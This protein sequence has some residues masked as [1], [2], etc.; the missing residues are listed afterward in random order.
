MVVK[1]G[2]RTKRPPPERRAASDRPALHDDEPS[3]FQRLHE[4]LGD[5][6]SHHLASVVHPLAPAV[7]QREGDS[8]GDVVG[9]RGR[10]LLGVSHA[11]RLAAEVERSQNGLGGVAFGLSIAN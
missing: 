9:L 10:E 8:L 1:C 5:N 11:G 7:A 6:A 4:P 3:A 2:R